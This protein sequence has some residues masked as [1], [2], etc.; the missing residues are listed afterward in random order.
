MALYSV[1]ASDLLLL[2]VDAVFV[3]FCKHCLPDDGKID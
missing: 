2:F 3:Q 1:V